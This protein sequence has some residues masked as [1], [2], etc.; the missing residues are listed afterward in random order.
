MCE[1]RKGP[2]WCRTLVGRAG[3][4][5]LRAK[6]AAPPTPQ[7]MK[8]WKFPGGG[9]KD[10]SSFIGQLT[11][12][13][14]AWQSGSSPDNSTSRCWSLL[15]APHMLGTV[16]RIPEP[17]EVGQVTPSIS[18]VRQREGAVACELLG[19]DHTCRQLVWRAPGSLARQ[20]CDSWGH[21]GRWESTGP[22]AQGPH[23]PWEPAPT[24]LFP[25]CPLLCALGRWLRAGRGQTQ[26]PFHRGGNW[27]SE[28]PH[29]ACWG[30]GGSSVHPN[31]SMGLGCQAE[32]VITPSGLEVK[33][34]QT[35]APPSA[36]CG[37]HLTPET[38]NVGM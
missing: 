31:P 3:A 8:A 10:M 5:C 22:G 34:N 38:S 21:S 1:D 18:W 6:R 32:G 28:T 24:C 17:Y 14:P 37:H 35:G 25:G 13:T 29:R 36:S 11:P 33:C 12:Q 23:S 30:R 16:L 27:G 9:R 7:T 19:S 20:E 2:P 4:L 15:G 26:A